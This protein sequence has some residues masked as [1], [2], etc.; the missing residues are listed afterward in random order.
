MDNDDPK[1]APPEQEFL[2]VKQT[3]KYLNISAS[4]V[5]GLCIT[6]KL[7]HYRFGD[8]SGAIRVNRVELME[9]VKRCRVEERAGKTHVEVTPRRHTKL[10]FLRHIDLR[11][12]HPCGAIT[13]AGT[14]C[15][16]PTKEEHCH[17][18]RKKSDQKKKR[19]EKHDE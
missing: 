10:R 5:Y 1:P 7:P 6:N 2:S 8:G 9:W 19:M 17:L 13:N 16:L 12:T 15:P 4:T 14:P 18:H 3:A 11:P